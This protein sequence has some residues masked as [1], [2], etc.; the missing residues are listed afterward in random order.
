M[1]SEARRTL[2]E[3]FTTIIEV[4]VDAKLTQLQSVALRKGRHMTKYSGRFPGLIFK[5]E[6]VRHLV[7][8][9]ELKQALLCGIL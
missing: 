7:S 4:S 2:K 5:L 6:I 3:M 9:R 8:K 1:P